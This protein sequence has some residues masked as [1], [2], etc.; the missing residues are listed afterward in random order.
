MCNLDR[1]LFMGYTVLEI[2]NIW[3]EHRKDVAQVG[4]RYPEVDRESIFTERLKS[5]TNSTS[6]ES[7]KLEAIV[8]PPQPPKWADVASGKCRAEGRPV[9][10]AT[11]AL[12]HASFGHLEHTVK[13]QKSVDVINPH[14]RAPEVQNLRPI[15]SK[16]LYTEILKGK[17]EPKKI[18]QSPGSSVSVPTADESNP[19]GKRYKAKKE[20]RRGFDLDDKSN[21]HKVETIP[22]NRKQQLEFFS[23]QNPPIMNSQTALL[24]E[25]SKEEVCKDNRI[26]G[27]Q[28]DFEA[29]KS[30]MMREI[31][32]EIKA[33]REAVRGWFQR[34]QMW[35]WTF[36]EGLG[37][38]FVE[39]PGYQELGSEKGMEAGSD[40]EPAE[41]AGCVMGNL[42]RNHGTH[43]VEVQ[44]ELGKG[45]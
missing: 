8:D 42:E 2:L 37:V 35:L 27:Q 17:T 38:E 32:Q 36:N 22:W 16:H 12:K 7:K 4:W 10:K 1:S 41:S 44:K 23:Q 19:T 45:E 34:L 15:D 31:D 28:R 11:P 25:Q 29:H 33:E 43:R 20:K 6:L 5:T 13:G 3:E 24:P 21:Y 26:S 39:I 18:S 9:P 40:H 14:D 30:R